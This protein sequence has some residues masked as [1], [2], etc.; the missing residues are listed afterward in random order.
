MWQGMGKA[1]GKSA[2]DLVGLESKIFQLLT[3]RHK[4]AD[5]S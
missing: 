4:Y 2:L 1:L 3:P 5:R